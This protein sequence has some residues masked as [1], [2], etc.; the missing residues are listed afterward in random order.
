MGG[1]LDPCSKKARALNRRYFKPSADPGKLGNDLTK[2]D[3]IIVEGPGNS[4]VRSYCY[5]IEKGINFIAGRSNN[6]NIGFAHLF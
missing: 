6:T 4:L 1:K 5:S 2:R 3:Y